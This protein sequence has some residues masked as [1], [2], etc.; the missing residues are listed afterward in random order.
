MKKYYRLSSLLFLSILA[1]C[2]VTAP[3]AKDPLGIIKRTEIVTPVENYSKTYIVPAKAVDK[4]D[5]A[6]GLVFH[7]P[8][9]TTDMV[10]TGT[11]SFDVTIDRSRGDV[12]YT[13]NRWAPHVYRV[14][15]TAK[16][17]SN[18]Y[19]VTFTPYERIDFLKWKGDS[20]QASSFLELER[21]LSQP[22]YS[23]RQ[24]IPSSYSTEA[25]IASFDQNK[26]AR[27]LGSRGNEFLLDIPEASKQG[28]A[29][30]MIEVVPYR[31]GSK[32]IVTGNPISLHY[33]KSVDK[34][35]VNL[36]AREKEIK[37]YVRQAMNS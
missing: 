11:H 31:N 17:V 23:F 35:V 26:A 32:V 6:F 9:R 20:T 15:A 22:Y 12:Q 8:E 21:M 3:T 2:Q 4:N 37:R 36:I 28:H 1:G 27:P 29:S 13:K 14:K 5:V 10:P 24:E 34:S 16:P 30:V 19:R 18:G 7:I 33:K 25:I